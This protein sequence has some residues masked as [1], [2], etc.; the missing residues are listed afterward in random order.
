L[1]TETR[2]SA[3][4]LR[5][6][7]PA[8]G[9]GNREAVARR[10]VAWLAVA[11][12]GLALAWPMQGGGGVPNAH[13][14]LVK[15]LADGTPVIDRSLGELGDFSTNDVA[16]F[17][18]RTYSNKAPGFAF[19]NLP[20]FVV[21]DAAGVRT[22]G[23]PARMLWVLGLWSVV[24]PT[25]LLVLLVRERADRL[26]PGFGTA[27]ALALGLG[28]LLLPYGTIF[29][30]HA[31][32]ALLVFAAFWLLWRE[33]EGP[34]RPW[35]L[36]AA[37][38]LAG[39]ATTTEYP[40]ALAA[41]VLGLYAIARSPRG[42]RALAYGTGVLVG[43][44]PL[45]LYNVWAFGSVTH[46]TYSGVAGNP[47]SDLFGAPSGRTLLELVASAN[48]LLV[49]T[50]VVSAGAVGTVLLWRRGGR[51]EALVVAGIALAFVVFNS[52]YFSPFGGPLP[53]PRHLIPI[54]AFL[55]VPL[56]LA[57][58]SLSATAGALALVSASTMTLVTATHALAGHDGR[59]LERLGDR[60]PTPTAA[61][62]AGVTGWVA[63]L[64]FFAAVAA[65]GA[66]AIAATAAPRVRA[67]DT[68]LAGVAA[69]GWAVVAAGAP[70]GADARE[71]SEYGAFWLV[72][73]LAAATALAVSAYALRG[74]APRSAARQAR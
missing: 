23:D 44:A 42:R 19:V 58:R 34:P 74:G 54:F 64:P 28:T 39:Y 68:L 37:G 53:G 20:V 26:T 7:T 63:I 27:A 50:P 38:L 48:G 8:A 55:A 18:G 45:A 70:R 51:P 30:S 6:R 11:L 41:C 4:R 66:C 15:A 36:A 1:P 57:L 3:R 35:A 29:L 67:A 2:L 9:G 69:L 59:W 5:R 71:L 17:E 13:Y 33:R 65:A 16:V 62:L 56:A 22:T 61:S 60:Q 31:L 73:A 12:L 40:N 24:L 52:A 25:L 72:L 49:L 46:S 43:L 32:S 21:L 47:A 10:R 14:V